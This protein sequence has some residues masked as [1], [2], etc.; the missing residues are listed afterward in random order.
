[1]WEDGCGI[2]G[3]KRLARR[4]TKRRIEMPPPT[5]ELEAMLELHF[6]ALLVKQYSEQ[7]IKARRDQ[8]QSLSTLVC[9]SRYQQ[10]S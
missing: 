5:N 7:T 2:T 10:S 3:V 4:H 6:E 9:R 8:V 1:M